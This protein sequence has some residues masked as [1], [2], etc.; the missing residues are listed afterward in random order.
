MEMKEFLITLSVSFSLLFFLGHSTSCEEESEMK[1]IA[2]SLLSNEEQKLQGG[3]EMENVSSEKEINVRF[4]LD[5]DQLLF[6]WPIIFREVSKLSSPRGIGHCYWNITLKPVSHNQEYDRLVGRFEGEAEGNEFLLNGVI[7][8]KY[9][10]I[11]ALNEIERIKEEG[12]EEFLESCKVR[13]TNKTTWEL[14]TFLQEGLKLKENPV[15]PVIIL[16]GARTG[17][18]YSG[19]WLVEEPL[20]IREYDHWWTF[21]AS[22]IKNQPWRFKYIDGLNIDKEVLLN[23]EEFEALEAFEGMPLIAGFHHKAI[24]AEDTNFPEKSYFRLALGMDQNGIIGSLSISRTE[25][26]AGGTRG[27]ELYGAFL[28]NAC[29][30]H[31]QDC[32]IEDIIKSM[33]DDWRDKFLK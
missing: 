21:V 3:L 33:N 7:K 24:K 22:I 14:S 20:L 17:I 29:Q 28:M 8:V 9:F 32:G 12:K 11:L 18:T 25:P 5:E 6:N 16:N 15:I 4:R 26:M 10:E 13:L 23:R 1:E 2:F 30:K 27:A 19:D 31:V